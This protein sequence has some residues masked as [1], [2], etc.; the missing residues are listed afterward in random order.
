MHCSWSHGIHQCSQFH[1]L[2]Q[3]RPGFFLFGVLPKGAPLVFELSKE[4]TGGFDFFLGLLSAS[5]VQADLR[6]VHVQIVQGAS[7]L[8]WPRWHCWPPSFCHDGA[9]QRKWDSE[10]H[11]T[12]SSRTGPAACILVSWLRRSS[13]WTLAK[14]QRSHACSLPENRNET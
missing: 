8:S 10:L 3:G 12:P 7:C 4:V 11:S 14:A 1:L 9:K 2:C 13:C 5:L 6:H